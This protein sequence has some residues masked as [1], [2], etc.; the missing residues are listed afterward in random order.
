M[1]GSDTGKTATRRINPESDN[2]ITKENDKVRGPA[3]R[4][5]C[6]KPAEFLPALERLRRGS[7][8]DVKTFTSGRVLD[9]LSK[10]DPSETKR[11]QF[12]D[13]DTDLLKYCRY[14]R[15][16]ANWDGQEDSTL[17]DIPENLKPSK[18]IIIGHTKITSLL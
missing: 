18:N 11:K 9:F 16:P 3:R 5:S 8:C 10:D 13:V 7:Y 12:L 1:D 4:D 14:L 15:T 6:R 2:N 17:D